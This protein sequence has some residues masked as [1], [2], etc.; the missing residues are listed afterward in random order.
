LKDHTVTALYAGLRPATEHKDYCIQ[1]NGDARYIT[2]GG[3][4]S[5]GLSAALGIA[6]HVADL[7][8]EQGTGWAP[9]SRPALPRVPNISET[10]P[11]DWQ[12][13][14]HDGIVCHCELATRREVLAALEGPLAARSLGGLKRRTR[15]TLG[16]CQGFYCSAS[17]AELTRDKFDR[18]IAE[19]VHAA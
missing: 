9:L 11:R 19:P 3:I 1:A 5:T 14:G 10:G 13:P 7:L 12:Q 2:V 18:P 6:R 15:V 8:A 17:L 16:R 4:R